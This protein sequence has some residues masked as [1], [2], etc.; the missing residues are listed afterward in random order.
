MGRGGEIG[1]EIRGGEKIII[2][3]LIQDNRHGRYIEEA[4]VLFTISCELKLEDTDHTY[5]EGDDRNIRSFKDIKW[6]EM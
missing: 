2:I 4:L 5:S 6:I 3:S 1:R